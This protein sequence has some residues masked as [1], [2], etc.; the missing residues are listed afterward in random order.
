MT[1]Q[2]WVRFYVLICA[3]WLALIF[4]TCT[5]TIR[6]EFPLLNGALIVAVAVA[7]IVAAMSGA[8]RNLRQLPP[9]F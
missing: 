8:R 5:A 2:G 1:S 9:E 6:G 3:M 4:C 7:G